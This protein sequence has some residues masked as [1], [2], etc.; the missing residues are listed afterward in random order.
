M[1][2]CRTFH[3]PWLGS[4]KGSFP[5]AASPTPLQNRLHRLLRFLSPS[6]HLPNTP[7]GTSKQPVGQYPPYRT[8]S[9][10]VGQ[11]FLLDNRIR[12]QCPAWGQGAWSEIAISSGIQKQHWPAKRSLLIARFRSRCFGASIHLGFLL[13]WSFTP[14][15][16]SCCS[17]MISAR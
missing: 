4:A 7:L 2:R 14:S 17:W 8:S 9:D 11:I 3:P 5:F 12:N 16:S 15:F 6:D 13:A 10:I 1:P